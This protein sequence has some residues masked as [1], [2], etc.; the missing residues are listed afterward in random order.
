MATITMEQTMATMTMEQYNAKQSIY[1]VPDDAYEVLYKSI[2][3]SIQYNKYDGAPSVETYLWTCPHKEGDCSECNYF[4]NI[5]RKG[6]NGRIVKESNGTLKPVLRLSE[7]QLLGA[8]CLG[9]F[10]QYKSPPRNTT[11]LPPWYCIVVG[12]RGI[13]LSISS[14]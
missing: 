12:R 11:S 5:L 1:V 10:V 8:G 2:L 6:C 14:L 9:T 13:D 3:M 7:Y 4:K